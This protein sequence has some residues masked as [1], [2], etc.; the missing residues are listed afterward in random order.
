VNIADTLS[1][2][3]GCPNARATALQPKEPSSF[4][5]SKDRV[6]LMKSRFISVFLQDYE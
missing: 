2:T 5:R 4:L 3:F 6:I 1:G